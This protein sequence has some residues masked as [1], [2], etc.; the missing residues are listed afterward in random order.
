MQ[1]PA[2]QPPVNAVDLA[3][4]TV[5][6]VRQWLSGAADGAAK[7][8]TATER[9]AGLVRDEAG[10]RFVIGLVDGVVRPSDTRVAARNFERLSR[11]VPR[12]FPAW[13]RIAIQLGGGFAV[14][15]PSL[16]V[17]LARRMF[18]RMVRPLVL[19]A[20]PGRL[21]KALLAA[22][23]DG[24]PLNLIVVGE[25]VLGARES[26]R[27]LADT[28][29][30]LA[31]HDVDHVSIEI[32]GVAERQ[33]AWAHEETVRQVV[34]RLGPLYEFAAASEIPKFISLD[35]R[36]Y[37]DLQLTLD[38]FTTLLERPS[39]AHLE[40]G[41][42]L[43][44]YLP[45]SFGAYRRLAA[46]AAA[47]RAAGGAGVK[48]R[49]VKGA[50]LAAERVEA[51]LHGWP[52]ATLPNKQ[53][54]DANFKRIVDWALTAERT[55]AVRL[56]VATHN[57]FDTAFAWHLARMRGVEDRIE[58]EMLRGLAP[59]LA[60]VVGDTV[61]G[62]LLYTPVVR[63]DEF[64]SAVAY[65]VRRLE[66]NA[67]SENFM[68]ALFSLGDTDSLFAR[69]ERRFRQSLQ[70]ASEPAVATNR[71]QS[72]IEHAAPPA[73]H[74]EFRASPPTD[75]SI[76]ENRTWA[77]QLLHR[78]Q[79]STLGA[80]KVANSVIHD[81]TRINQ[82]V[83]E[84]GAAAAHWASVSL[85]QREQLLLSI[86]AVFE[87]YRGRFIE[88]LVSEVGCTL[89]EADAE[90]S[91]AI[92]FARYYAHTANELTL[93]DHA[94][95]IPSA[96]TLVGPSWVSPIAD[97]AE[98]VCAALAAGGATVVAPSYQARRSTALVVEALAEAGVPAGL[99]SLAVLQSTDL[100]RALVS[101]P[102]VDRVIFSGAAEPAALLRTWRP[103]RPLLAEPPG[104]SSIIVTPSADPDL[105]VADIVASAFRRGGQHRAATRLVI[106]VGSTTA[107]SP[108]RLQ[109][110]DAVESVHL[111]PSHDPGVAVGSLLNEARGAELE[112]LTRL[113]PGEHWL[114]KPRTLDGTGRA[115]SPGVRDS[116]APQAALQS[117]AAAAPVISLVTVE[118]LDEAIELQNAGRGLVAGIHSLDVVEVAIWL[119]TSESGSLFVN[120]AVTDRVERHPTGGWHGSAPKAGGPNRLLSLGEW[121]P[122]FS[123]QVQSVSLAGVDERAKAVIEAAQ[124]AMKFA[125]FG[126]VREGA[127]SDELAWQ[128]V[129]SQ[130]RD[131]TGKVAQRN[132][133]RYLPVATT[134]R[135]AEGASLS[136][137]IRVLA[138]AARANATVSISSAEPLP[139]TLIRLFG[140]PM[141]PLRVGQV[142]IE[143]D[144]RWHSRIRAGEVVTPR[145]RLVGGDEE[146]LSILL[147]ETPR[148]GL[149]AGPVTTSGR[150]ELLAFL[151]EQSVAITAHR[152]GNHDPVI[153]QLEF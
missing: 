12:S 57:L 86:A 24:T 39:L 119:D 112:A 114:V 64:S 65:L 77:R 32:S 126:L 30:L 27:R 2:S 105:A 117:G 25:A 132:V 127:I 149:F 138:A 36:E 58:F 38:V 51:E 11:D 1:K 121:Q 69:E 84:A 136:Q 41:V 85:E 131:E 141:P 99:V 102:A 26:E 3:E 34:G 123:E 72:R 109:L 21:D 52:L 45:E 54:T 106:L 80:P 100:S 125:E 152:Y 94:T 23:N 67:S 10:L 110:A 79:R 113:A 71:V 63:A 147:A 101:H 96:L 92:D 29:E 55:D 143:S 33:E 122:V 89:T 8:D 111:G 6:T 91:Q 144:R 76:A 87:T 18:R 120:S 19:D 68:S 97:A 14:L 60:A 78:A 7:S 42:V 95:F 130:A 56:G 62:V 49:L 15:L 88:T 153:A 115:W 118:T 129:Y 83:S 90:A 103:T 22:R 20:D 31:R 139:E 75:P 53:E 116:A 81:E 82:L 59:K 134:V 16:V 50:N 46:W 9:L 44:A 145:I 48:V 146:T 35:M 107:S 135:L 74:S 142:I 124:S 151:R 40:A 47:R 4:L 93:V 66:E 28:F 98:A 133:L 128:Q 61:G 17:P 5:T 13:L 140:R 150:L 70:L 148:V 104:V 137:L 43:Q 73:V 108:F 37:R